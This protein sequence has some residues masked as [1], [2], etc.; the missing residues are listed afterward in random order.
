MLS[1]AWNVTQRVIFQ[2]H[3]W[4]QSAALWGLCDSLSSQSFLTFPPNCGSAFSSV[5]GITDGNA[6]L[7]CGYLALAE[8]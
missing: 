4:T 8:V 5:L 2:F 1:A 7:S 3:D 6:Y